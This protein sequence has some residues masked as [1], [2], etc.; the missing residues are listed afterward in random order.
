MD[1]PKIPDLVRAEDDPEYLNEARRLLGAYVQNNYD[2]GYTVKGQT[3]GQKS[4]LKDFQRPGQTLEDMLALAES[5][6]G[7]PIPEGIVKPIKDAA[8][9]KAKAYYGSLE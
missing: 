2:P 6:L 9:T 4:I 3:P 8:A 7:H 5:I 1:Y